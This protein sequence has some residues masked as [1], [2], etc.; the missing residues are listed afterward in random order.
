MPTTAHV[1]DAVDHGLRPVSDGHA[2]LQD[3][4]R[5]ARPIER[6]YLVFFEHDPS[7]AAGFIRE[8]DGKRSVER[9]RSELE[10]EIGD[11]DMPRDRLASSAAAACTTW[12]S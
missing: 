3:G 11:A 4:V 12:R 7:M 5:R 8:Q 2:G 9:V 10:L 6:E 1:P